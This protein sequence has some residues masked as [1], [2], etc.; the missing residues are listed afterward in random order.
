[1]FTVDIVPRK[2]HQ[3]QCSCGKLVFTGVLTCKTSHTHLQT[4]V[5]ACNEI[6]QKVAYWVVCLK[7]DWLVGAKVCQVHP[8]PRCDK[9][10]L[11]LD[12][13]MTYISLVALGQS[14]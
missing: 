6:V 7:A 9:H 2:H 13:T 1:M 12:I 8:V 5:K 14:M 10:I 3:S 11:T 4:K